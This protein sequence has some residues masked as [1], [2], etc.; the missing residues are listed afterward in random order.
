M[1]HDSRTR[2]AE[3]CGACDESPSSNLGGVKERKAI[4]GDCMTSQVDGR[5]P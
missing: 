4:R 5:G 3:T 2:L 1:G